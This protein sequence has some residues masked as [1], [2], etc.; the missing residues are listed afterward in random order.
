MKSSRK[1][2]AVGRIE[3]DGRE[4]MRSRGTAKQRGA[5]NDVRHESGPESCTVPGLIALQ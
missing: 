4:R 2:E 1:R 5:S 3:G